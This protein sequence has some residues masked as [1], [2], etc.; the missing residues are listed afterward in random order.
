MKK[1]IWLFIKMVVFVMV[2][3]GSVLTMLCA[4]IKFVQL[5]IPYYTLSHKLT[6]FKE[7]IAFGILSIIYAFAA[8]TTYYY[9]K[10]DNKGD[11]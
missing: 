7:V 9:I 1:K 11:N 8:L 3:A 6:A 5:F 4:L 2:S 10:S